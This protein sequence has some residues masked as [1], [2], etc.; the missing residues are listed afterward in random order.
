M[1]IKI[2]CGNYVCTKAI[3]RLLLSNIVYVRTS[4]QISLDKIL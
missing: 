4:L 1:N 3:Y 2:V